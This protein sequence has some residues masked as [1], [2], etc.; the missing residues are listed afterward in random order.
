ML[1]HVDRYLS[2]QRDILSP[3]AIQNLQIARDELKRA[4]Q[5]NV[6]K[7]GLRAQMEKMEAVAN[8]NFR[9][10][11]AAAWRE[12]VEVLLVAIAVAMGIRTF[13]I[14][15]FKIPTGSMQPTLY[16]ITS[17]PDYLRPFSADYQA[18]PN[19]DIPNPI[20]RFFKFWYTG[21]SYTHIKARRDGRLKDVEDP[22][23]FLL[24]N[25]HQR[26]WLETPSGEIDTYHIWFPPDDLFRRAGLVKQ[27]GPYSASLDPR[28]IKAGD[29]IMKIKVISGDHL[30][31]DRLT[32]NFRRPK[33][34]EIIVFETGGIPR[35][36]QDQFYI[37]RMVAMGN[38]KV[39]IGNDRHLRLDG[40]RLDTN[41]PHFEKVYSFPSDRPPMD[42]VYSGHLNEFVARQYG[43][44][45]APNFDTEKDVF[46]VR[47]DHYIVM[48]DNTV[49]SSD[50]RSWGDFPQ[51]NVIGRSFL[52]YWP[53][54][55]QD[56]RKSRFGWGNR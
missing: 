34:G 52:V 56:G 50:S 15:P 11:A 28:V 27:Y 5:A 37:K 38:N 22:K 1:K 14:Q 47:P 26:F 35:L 12:N 51:E 40:K 2:A 45:L 41:T 13:F 48:G 29:D 44:S 49:N 31:V 3:D 30:F 6:P 18:E 55:P 16:G 42:S 33:L 25:L 24:F 46:T 32:Y 43:M 54:G 20:V 10:Y 4:V 19:F 17:T 8:K 21:V 23:R 7:K 36:P 9:P 53:F 39:Q